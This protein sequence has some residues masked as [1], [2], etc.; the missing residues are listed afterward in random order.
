MLEPYA[1]GVWRG[2]WYVAGWDPELRRHA[3]LPPRPH[4]GAAL[5]PGR[6][7]RRVRR[8]RLVPTPTS[9][10]TSTRTRGATTRCCTPA[11]ASSATTSPRSSTTSAARSST[12]T[13]AS[14]STVAFD[15]APLRVDPQ[16]HPRVPRPRRRRVA[17]RARRARRATTCGDRRG[18][19]DGRA[20][21]AAGVR[22]AAGDVRAR[23][24]ARLGVARGGGASWS[25][26]TAATLR[27]VLA[28]AV[29]IEFRTPDG[30]IVHGETA[31]VLYDDD[32]LVA[33]PGP[34]AAH[35]ARRTT[36][37]RR[38]RCAC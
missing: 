6:R 9:P 17:A 13:T 21:Q 19:R 1:L 15:R 27:D 11:C 34:L 23:R 36:A 26:S 38:P 4:R 8:R 16:P 14:T 7:G 3:S 10:S 32:V 18:R 28:P 24:G 29:L 2:R 31:F 20:Q 33:R 5:D 12:S 35:L 30:D 37:A 22:H 25:A